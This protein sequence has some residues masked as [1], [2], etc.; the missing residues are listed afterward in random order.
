MVYIVYKCVFLLH[1]LVLLLAT[2]AALVMASVSKFQVTLARTRFSNLEVRSLNPKNIAKLKAEFNLVCSLFTC[3]LSVYKSQI[4]RLIYLVT[5]WQNNN[6]ITF[7]VDHY[8]KSKTARL[9]IELMVQTLQKV[10]GLFVA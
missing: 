1:S 2:L 9:N 7:A 8:I 5:L 3:F 10:S 4:E 6:W